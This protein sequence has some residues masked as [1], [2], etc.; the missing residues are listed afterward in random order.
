VAPPERP[1]RIVCKEPRERGAEEPSG[2][3]GTADEDQSIEGANPIVLV[4]WLSATEENG[5]QE[6]KEE[7]DKADDEHESQHS[8]RVS[9]K[10]SF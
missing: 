2:A 3:A 10:Q 5:E 6:E 1:R 7:D 9:E 4:I 8:K